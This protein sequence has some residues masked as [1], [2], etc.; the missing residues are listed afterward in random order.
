MSL[1]NQ[2]PKTVKNIH[3]SKPTDVENLD[4]VN[5][6]GSNIEHKNNDLQMANINSRNRIIPTI[7][8]S[9]I[10]NPSLNSLSNL[11]STKSKKRFG[12][13]SKYEDSVLNDL[14][15]SPQAVKEQYLKSLQAH[16]P[17]QRPSLK[18]IIK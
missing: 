15:S 16:S 3:F 14:M 4:R 5:N 8:Q 10:V 1:Q 13:V 11:K 2:Y 18:K 9:T 12:G 6:S 17:D 7:R